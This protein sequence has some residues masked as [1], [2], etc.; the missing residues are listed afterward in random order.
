MV[1]SYDFFGIL[2]ISRVTPKTKKGEEKHRIANVAS[3][4]LIRDMTTPVK[5]ERFRQWV[6][7]DVFPAG[8]RPPF[9][10]L[11]DAPVQFVDDVASYERVKV[12]IFVIIYF[13]IK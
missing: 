12:G 5:C 3:D 10:L 6:I 8:G 1:L 11:P 2:R 9:E 4:F 13:F 7:E